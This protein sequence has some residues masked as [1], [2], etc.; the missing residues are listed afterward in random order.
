MEMEDFESGVFSPAFSFSLS[1]LESASDFSSVL[2]TSSPETV[3]VVNSM[4]RIFSSF[5]FRPAS[6]HFFLKSVRLVL[7]WPLLSFESMSSNQAGNWFGL[8]C[9]P[10]CRT[11]NVNWPCARPV[12][13]ANFT[14]SSRFNRPAISIRFLKI[15]LRHSRKICPIENARISRKHATTRSRP[16][17]VLRIDWKRGS[18]RWSR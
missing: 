7:S 8:P 13:S 11:A 5:N 15:V 2:A 14:P 4:S 1:D 12:Y 18:R 9:H 16:S 6:V 10:F 3:S 17:T